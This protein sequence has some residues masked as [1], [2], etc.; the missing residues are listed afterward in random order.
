[1]GG[2][3]SENEDDLWDAFI[4]MRKNG[5]TEWTFEKKKAFDEN[6]I[7]FWALHQNS[8]YQKLFRIAKRVY[9]IPASST[10][11]ELVIVIEQ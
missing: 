1:M 8:K 2:L 11:S 7:A 9:V 4:N 10:S 6:P 3:G 5:V